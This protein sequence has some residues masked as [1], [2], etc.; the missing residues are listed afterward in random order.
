MSSG[1]R[2]YFEL[3]PATWRFAIAQDRQTVFPYIHERKSC[4]PPFTR[5]ASM[6][7]TTGFCILLLSGLIGQAAAQ[8]PYEL[9]LGYSVP[10]SGELRSSWSGGA[11]A[12]ISLP[13]RSSSREHL[14][15]DLGGQLFP[16]TPENHGPNLRGLRVLLSEH[17]FLSADNKSLQAFA[18]LG[19]QYLWTGRQEPQPLTGIPAPGPGTSDGVIFES[20]GPAGTVGLGWTLFGSPH[21]QLQL[22]ASWTMTRVDGTGQSFGVLGVAYLVG[23]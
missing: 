11:A 3:V 13:V 10:T 2:D 6:K 23:S 17:F 21:N 4:T 22:Q 14:S 18:G 5:W 1:W 20:W 9:S 7:P 15:L 12:G 16:T 8:A 19:I